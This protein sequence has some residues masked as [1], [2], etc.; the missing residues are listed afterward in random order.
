MDGIDKGQVNHSAA[1]VYETFFV[2][3]LFQEWAVRVVD[4]AQIQPGQRVLDVACGTG[5]VARTAAEQVG[6]EGFVTGLD[7]N[8]GMLS[9]AR[10]KNT[11]IDWRQGRAEALP[12]DDHTFDAV[13]SQFGLMFFEDRATAIQE[14]MRVLKPGGRLTVAVWGAL[15]DTPGYAALTDLLQ[16]LFGEKAADSLRMPYILGD[17]QALKT[18]FTEAGLPDAH[19]T[20]HDGTARFPSIDA[21]M[22]TDIKGWVLADMLDD[23]QFALLLKEAQQT[24]KPFINADGKVAFRSPAHIVTAV[25]SR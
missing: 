19:I 5:I 20:T 23:D 21:W 18:I 14:M 22:Y 12:F 17:T 13:I 11:T 25:K 24:L 7:I 8:D 3:A 15:D 10:Q 16:H 6:S 9:V 1:K 4:A 2:P